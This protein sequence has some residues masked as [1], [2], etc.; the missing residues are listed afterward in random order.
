MGGELTQCQVVYSPRYSLLPNHPQ[1]TLS[2]LTAAASTCPQPLQTQ[3]VP[4]DASST[5]TPNRGSRG[6]RPFVH[7]RTLHAPW[8]QRHPVPCI[9]SSWKE[10][11][12]VSPLLLTQNL[13]RADVWVFPQSNRC[14]STSWVCYNS[15]QFSHHPQ[16]MVHPT[17]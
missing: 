2:I 13:P 7:P 15:I 16:L 9:I 1:S 11:I 17:D 12:L 5:E 10:K 4:R 6:S 3:M 8:L 14:S